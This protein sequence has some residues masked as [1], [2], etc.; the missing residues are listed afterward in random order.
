[1]DDHLYE[2][3]ET[4]ILSREAAARSEATIDCYRYSLESYGKFAPNWPPTPDAIRAFLS[5][6]RVRGLSPTTIHDH[7]ARLAVW[8]RWLEAEGHLKSNP[9][10]RV[11]RP[12]VPHPLPRGARPADVQAII[13]YLEQKIA[14]GG[15]ILAKRD[16]ALISFTFDTG[17]RNKEI[18][19]LRMDALYLCQRAAIVHG[20]GDKDRL[21]TF[22]RRTQ[23]TVAQWLE[24]RPSLAESSP[25]VFVTRKGNQ[26]TRFVVLQIV[27]QAAQRAD[28]EGKV[29]PHTLRHASTLGM[30]DLGANIVD[31]KEQMG[32][33]DITMTE[34]YAQVSLA[35]RRQL[36]EQFSPL[37]R[38]D[39]LVAADDED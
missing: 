12:S 16:L 10:D 21:V 31:V 28:I 32:H 7:W 24:V 2:A 39:E 27:K 13:L 14:N 35:H 36:H 29:T 38:L 34:H 3:I 33:H 9:M 37:D 17:A 23:K 8:L 19:T 18:R 5:D 11:E 20:K 15:D 26:M 25:Y 22:G 30:L 1:M 6:C 4:F